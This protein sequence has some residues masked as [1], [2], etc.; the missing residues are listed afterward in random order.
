MKDFLEEAKKEQE[1]L[2]IGMKESLRAKKERQ[3]VKRVFCIGNG[4]SRIGFDL[5]RLR[6]LGKIY[7]CNAIHRDFMPDV[8]TAVD[9]GIMHEVYHAGIAQ[10]IPCY[11]RDWTKVPAMSYE[12]VVLNGAEDLEVQKHIKDI[13][14]SNSRGDSKEY[15][16]HGANLKGIV[17]MIKRNGEKYKKN[18]NNSQ[19]KVSWIK[20]PDYSHS[21]KDLKPIM[22][23]NTGDF[24]W[25]CGASSG[26]VSILREKP[27]QIFL[28]G[29]D[30]YSHND[31]INNLYKSTKHYTAKDNGPTPAVNWIRQWRTLMDWYPD[32]KF[33]KIN[34]FND[35]RDNVNTHI[36]EWSGK[37]NLTYADYSTLDNLT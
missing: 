36:D 32:I 12:S 14:I 6:P 15:V 10:K 2:D 30:L 23:Q 22:K 26:Y 37:E 31:K 17:D 24:G 20:E 18:V 33:I 3:E 9:H 11:F 29:H 7:G 8:L 16:Y 35:G 13:I 28:I 4:E 19:I 5:E 21:I 1:I 25:A 34:R 27:D